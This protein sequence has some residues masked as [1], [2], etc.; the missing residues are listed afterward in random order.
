M[1]MASDESFYIAD[2]SY[3]PKQYM[4]WLHYLPNIHIYYAVKTNGK[5]FI[6]QIIEKLGS[7]FDCAS[8]NE[9]DQVL[10]VCPE[11]DF[12]ERIIYS[13][14]CKSISHIKYFHANHVRLTVVDNIQEMIKIHTY[15]PNAKVLLLLKTDNSQS[16]IFCSAKFGV[17]KK[18]M[19]RKLFEEGKKLQMDIVGC[20]FHVDSEF[21]DLMA[22]KKAFLFAKTIM[23]LGKE[24]HFDM[25]ILDIGGGFPGVDHVN[26]TSFLQ[27]TA[28]I[29]TA[30]QG[31][32]PQNRGKYQ[33]L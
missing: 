1:E 12:S 30:I 26:K 13:H 29:R 28:C 11:F 14:P 2:V 21:D 9:L 8:I 25:T 6:L 10:S 7:G 24:Y 16:F 27:G 31:Y 22:F 19:A 5:R 20:A 23:D 33:T 32:F 15:W 4:K 3:C 18:L 17:D